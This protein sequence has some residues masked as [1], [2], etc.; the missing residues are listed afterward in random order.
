MMTVKGGVLVT[1][2]SKKY[3][4]GLETLINLKNLGGENMSKKYLYGLETQRLPV[5]LLQN[6]RRGV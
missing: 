5:N 3:L 4:Y 1:G 6:G 2:E